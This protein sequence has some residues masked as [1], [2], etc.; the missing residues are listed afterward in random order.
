MRNRR[1][2]DFKAVSEVDFDF[3]V[4][5]GAING[6]LIWTSSLPWKMQKLLGFLDMSIICSG[7]SSD[8]VAFEGSALKKCLDVGVLAPDL[9]LFGDKNTSIHIIW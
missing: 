5:A 8:L 4:C 2:S 3:D 7:A 1:R 9:C 6:I